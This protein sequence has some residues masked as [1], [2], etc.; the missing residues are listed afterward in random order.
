MGQHTFKTYKSGVG[1]TEIEKW[2]YNTLDDAIHA[3]KMSNSKESTI[4]KY[5]A[6][7]CDICCKYHI[8][9]SK[10]ELKDKDR[11][12]YQKELFG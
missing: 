9:K 2:S 1:F 5:V 4:H 7:K 6:Y 12:K 8:G 10:R 3:A 11:L